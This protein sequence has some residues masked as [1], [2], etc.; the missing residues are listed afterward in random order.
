MAAAN[1]KV[2]PEALRSRNSTTF[3]GSYQ[4]L[5]SAL[6]NSA[7]IIKFVNNSN[8]DVTVSWNGSTDHDFIPA[9]SA[10]VIDV[11]ANKEALTFGGGQLYVGA[12]TQFYVK[13]AAGGGNS[14]SVYLIVL[15]A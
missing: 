10:W 14:G 5:G 8:V 6:S 4:T 7:R 12:Q 1:I 11:S 13:G 9:H 15:Y 3:T 2:L